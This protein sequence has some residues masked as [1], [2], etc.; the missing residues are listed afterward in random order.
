MTEMEKQLLSALESLQ[1]SYEQQLQ[2]WQASY[3]SLQHMFE[4]TSQALERSDRVCQH[5]SSQVNSLRDQVENL[6]C[7][8]SRLMRS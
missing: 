3:S 5:L 6:S 2:A 8:V 4:T 1:T 7:N